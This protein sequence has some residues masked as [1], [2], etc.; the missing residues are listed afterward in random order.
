MQRHY[1]MR[2]EVIWGCGARIAAVLG[3]VSLGELK[4]IRLFLRIWAWPRLPG[5]PGCTPCCSARRGPSGE[6]SAAAMEIGKRRSELERGVKKPNDDARRRA[7]DDDAAHRRS[8]G[9]KGPCPLSAL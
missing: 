4:R 7:H 3:L 6:W 1:A 5:W 2:V 8:S 9:A